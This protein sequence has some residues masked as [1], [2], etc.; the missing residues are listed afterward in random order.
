VGT[1]VTVDLSRGPQLVLVPDVQGDSIN[2]AVAALQAAGLQVPEVV[3]P[4]FATQAT[5][6]NPAPGSQVQPGSSVTLYAA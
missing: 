2:D 4:P 6:T 5:T 1:T 3:G